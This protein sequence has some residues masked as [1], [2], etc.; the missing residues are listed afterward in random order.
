VL[1]VDHRWQLEEAADDLGVDRACLRELKVLLGRAFGGWLRKTGRPA[2][3]W[4][5]SMG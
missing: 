4:T 5:T 2:C 1:A 3:S